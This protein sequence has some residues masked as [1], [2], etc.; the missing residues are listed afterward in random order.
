[1]CH[2]RMMK[3]FIIKMTPEDQHI[4]RLFLFITFLFVFYSFD[5]FFNFRRKTIFRASSTCLFDQN[6][7]VDFFRSFFLFFYVVKIFLFNPPISID[8]TVNIVASIVNLLLRQRKRAFFT[9]NYFLRDLH[10]FYALRNMKKVF[11]S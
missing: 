11:T 8:V 9:S 4:A 6:C 7:F 3:S 1:M 5:Y 10:D 2:K